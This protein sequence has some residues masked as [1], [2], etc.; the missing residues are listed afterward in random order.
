MLHLPL[1][2]SKDVDL[3][4]ALRFGVEA[5]LAPLRTELREL[6]ARMVDR[7]RGGREQPKSFH[8]R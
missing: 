8:L 7:A 2:G 6:C 4:Q 5:G 1:K 3:A